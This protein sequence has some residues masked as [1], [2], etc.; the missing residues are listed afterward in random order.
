MV[1]RGSKVRVL[2]PESYWFQDLGT[3]VSVDKSGIKY[4]VIVR[5]DK[6]NYSD[7]NTNNFAV[8]ELIEVEAPKP[9]AAA[10]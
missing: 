3:V 5:F 10:K 4:P 1:Q 7:L 8:D 2:R 9:K 6:V